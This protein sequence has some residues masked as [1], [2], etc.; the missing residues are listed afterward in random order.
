MNRQMIRRLLCISFTLK[1]F[2]SL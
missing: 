2:R 1:L